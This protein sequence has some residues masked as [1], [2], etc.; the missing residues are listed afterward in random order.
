MPALR[1]DQKA[2][3]SAL[4]DAEVVCLAM[5]RR[6]G[7][8]TLGAVVCLTFAACGGRVAWVV[9][10]YK[11]GRPL[12]RQAKLYLAELKAAG[13]ARVNE[14]E[15]TVE[16]SA[17]YGGGFL[18]IYSAEDNC[19]AMRGEDLDLVVIDE[20]AKVP[21]IAW[22]DAI[23]P[24]LAD[25]AGR[26]L[27][28]S[29]PRGQNWFYRLWLDG[30]GQNEED[31]ETANARAVR[32]FC[33]PSSA[34]PNPNIQRAAEL[35]RERV[36]E[37]TYRQEWL[38]EFLS[39]GGEVFRNVDACIDDTRPLDPTAK[40]SA[41][42]RP[43][44]MGVDLA[45]MDD[46][47]VCVVADV[48]TRHVVAFERYNKADWPVQKAR[49][50]QLARHWNNAHIWIDATGVGSP[51]YDDLAFAG[52]RVSPY[53]F[54]AQSKQAMYDNAVLLVEQRK[55]TFPRIP[56]LINELKSLQFKPLP[57]GNVRIEAPEGQHDDA[58]CA[59]GLMCLELAAEH[60]GLPADAISAIMGDAAAFGGLDWMKRRF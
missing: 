17:A 5:G 34:N 26:A 44:V 24:T 49:I 31:E 29:T 14:S 52:L 53:H 18:G 43:Y 16:F 3:V 33:A 19:D 36:S 6:W 46:F 30:Q 9:P 59:F 45:K 56:A 41:P 60:V 58:A 8:T 15:R 38:A 2:I 7:K 50:A 51:I 27:A 47:T 22:T 23:Q 39:D 25:R 11:N 10:T 21:E 20:A 57:S 28:I 35:A 37:R 40:P 42:T 54:T 55:I 32:S 1:A 4:R 12:W 13:A 48:W